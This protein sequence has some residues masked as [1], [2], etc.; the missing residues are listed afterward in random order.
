MLSS[1]LV[2]FLRLFMAVH[3]IPAV[4]VVCPVGLLDQSI[5]FASLLMLLCW[6]SSI[7]PCCSDTLTI[8][9]VTVT[10]F[11][12]YLSTLADLH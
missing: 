2:F 7:L 10:A 8:V 1:Y 3:N 5:A 12:I 4:C 6:F 11:S 9:M